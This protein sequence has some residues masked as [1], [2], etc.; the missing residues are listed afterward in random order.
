VTT[1]N[2][3]A[4]ESSGSSD[5]PAAAS[6]CA[7]LLWRPR[8]TS[9]SPVCLAARFLY[10]RNHPRQQN[11]KGFQVSHAG[12]H[13]HHAESRAR[14]DPPI[15]CADRPGPAEAPSPCPPPRS[16]IRKYLGKKF[17]VQIGFQFVPRISAEFIFPPPHPSVQDVMGAYFT[18]V[19]QHDRGL[20]YYL[21]CSSRG[22]H[23]VTTPYLRARYNLKL[24]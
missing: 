16:K 9:S 19:V 4:P 23:K 10:G 15:C 12:V 21:Q 2:S 13:A 14:P 17:F 22:C 1:E 7:A 24:Q 6:G 8:P 18:T 20:I 11:L 3:C 5:A